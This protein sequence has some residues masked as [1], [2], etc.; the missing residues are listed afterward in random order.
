MYNMYDEKSDI[1]CA[2][3]LR[4][5]KVMASLGKQKTRWFSAVKPGFSEEKW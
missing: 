3:P 5:K 4:V 2:R 1:I